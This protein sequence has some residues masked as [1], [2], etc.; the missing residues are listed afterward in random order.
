MTTQSLVDQI[1][2]IRLTGRISFSAIGLAIIVF[3]A[4]WITVVY[5]S[6]VP[7]MIAASLAEYIGI[8]AQ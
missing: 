5:L 2:A 6:D 7:R 8:L 1:R 3:V 4:L